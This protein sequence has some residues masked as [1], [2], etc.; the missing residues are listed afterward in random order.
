MPVCLAT[1]ELARTRPVRQPGSTGHAVLPRPAGAWSMTIDQ[2]DL[3]DNE[4]RI[5]LAVDGCE[6]GYLLFIDLA[7]A[8][9]WIDTINVDPEHRG[10]GH[11][12]RLLSLVLALHPARTAGL[13][14][15]T[16]ALAAWYSRAG[17]LPAGPDGTM[18]WPATP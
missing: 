12:T 8:G 15:P 11:G 14:A 1:H 10:N 18:R 9:V 7:D 4:G 13:V 2:P 17:F 5:A 3:D 16:S 6:V